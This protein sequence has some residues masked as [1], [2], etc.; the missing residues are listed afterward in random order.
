M[1]QAR[2]KSPAENAGLPFGRRIRSLAAAWSAWEGRA[3]A[4]HESTLARRLKGIILK[5]LIASTIRDRPTS[6]SKTLG[7]L[8]TIAH[9][10]ELDGASCAILAAS[11]R[12]SVRPARRTLGPGDNTMGGL[13]TRRG[14]AWSDSAIAG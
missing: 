13:S 14:G 8:Q 2:L 4:G 3:A 12:R 10:G 5:R 1:P 7:R 11:S 9:I 6:S